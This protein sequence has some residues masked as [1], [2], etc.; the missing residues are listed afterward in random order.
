MEIVGGFRLLESLVRMGS[1]TG[2]VFVRKASF[3]RDLPS[4]DCG[5]KSCDHFEK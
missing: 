2:I 1:R 4:E 3:S 5:G